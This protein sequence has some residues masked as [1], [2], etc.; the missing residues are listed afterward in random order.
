[1]ML[2]PPNK[3]ASQQTYLR[4]TSS[5]GPLTQIT[6]LNSTEEEQ[7]MVDLVVKVE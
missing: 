1:M 3:G 5:L 4:I 2:L 7:D 6:K